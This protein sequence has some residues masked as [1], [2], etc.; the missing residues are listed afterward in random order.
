MTVFL[1]RSEKGFFL[2]ILSPEKLLICPLDNLA[3][4][5][6]LGDITGLVKWF[7]LKVAYCT[8]KNNYVA[9]CALATFSLVQLP[10][11]KKV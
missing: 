2:F 11:W 4:M 9:V 5:S 3:P 6:H 8:P 10:A 7:F 1:N